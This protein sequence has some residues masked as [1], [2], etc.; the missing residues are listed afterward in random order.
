MGTSTR[1]ASLFLVALAVL[2]SRPVPVHA[3]IADPTKCSHDL[4]LVGNSS[5]V[6]LSG[7]HVTVRD[8][9]NI[10]LPGCTVAVILTSSSASPDG[11]QETGTT[12]DCPTRTISRITDLDGSVV[13]HAR[14]AGYDNNLVQVRANGVL[15]GTTV[16]R[17]TDIDGNGTTDIRDLNLFRQRYLFNPTAPETDFNQD[18]RTDLYDL[19][20]MRQEILRNARESPCP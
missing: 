14:I 6:S 2:A 3:K 9:G 5:G 18:G 19:D 10:P 15:L 11:T 20:V 13:F 1:L 17:S 7:Y 8:V 4:V 12:T 16:V